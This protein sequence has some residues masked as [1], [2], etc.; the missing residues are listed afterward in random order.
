MESKSMKCTVVES[1]KAGHALMDMVYTIEY[2]FFWHVLEMASLE[3]LIHDFFESRPPLPP[4]TTSPPSPHPSLQQL[5]GIFEIATDGEME[6]LERVLKYSRE[7]RSETTS[8][9]SGGT[10]WFSRAPGFISKI[11]GRWRG[12]ELSDHSEHTSHRGVRIIGGAIG[13]GGRSLF[14]PS[15]RLSTLG[16]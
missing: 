15:P 10:T 2:L 8:I 7:M 3:E 16:V 13:R 4:T 11:Y 6:V 12:V 1:K 14:Y 9:S 5:E